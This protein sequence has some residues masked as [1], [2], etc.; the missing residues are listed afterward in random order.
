MNRTYSR[1][2][3]IEI[4]N[5]LSYVR[6]NN[7]TAKYLFLQYTY[8]CVISIENAADRSLHIVNDGRSC[9]DETPN[10]YRRSTT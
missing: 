8:T 5:F 1:H 2:L 4:Y 10:A 9:S 3:G 7:S 6:D